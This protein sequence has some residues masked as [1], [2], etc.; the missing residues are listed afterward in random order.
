MITILATAAVI[1]LL[2]VGS[3]Y[4]GDP[5]SAVVHLARGSRSWRRMILLQG[6]R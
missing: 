5:I 4:I 2:G 3:A 1:G 6:H